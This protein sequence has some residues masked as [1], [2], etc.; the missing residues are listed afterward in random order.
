MP[1]RSGSSAD[2][3]PSD[4]AL[5]AELAMVKE[6]AAQ[7]KAALVEAQRCSL[8]ALKPR[9]AFERSSFVS[10]AGGGRGLWRAAC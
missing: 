2:T 4:E 3:D 5:A 7:A 1:K 10:A 9:N 6:A 8:E